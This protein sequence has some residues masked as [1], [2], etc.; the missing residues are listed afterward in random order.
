MAMIKDSFAL[1]REWEGQYGEGFKLE[2]YATYQFRNGR[3]YLAYRFTHNGTVIF[4]GDDYGPSPCYAVDADKNVA[5][6]LVFL[7]CKPGDT[8]DEYFESYTPEQL[9]WAE[10]HGEALYLYVEELEGR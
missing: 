10:Q 3:E 2:L 8:D 1:I 4:E 9:E 5:G 7:A 6:L